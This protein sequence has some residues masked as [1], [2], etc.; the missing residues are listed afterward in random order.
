[1]RD[2]GWLMNQEHLKEDDQRLMVR[3]F[4]EFLAMVVKMRQRQKEAIRLKYSTNVEKR[5]E[6]LL[7]E[8]ESE[9]AVDKALSEIIEELY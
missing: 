9:R 2:L 8:R 3:K 6:A 5:A 4:D 7:Q 1:M